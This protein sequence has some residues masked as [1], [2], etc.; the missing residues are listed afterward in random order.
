MSF[1][2][3]R[4]PGAA[5]LS[6]LVLA[7]CAAIAPTTPEEAVGRRA[8]ARIDALV[9]KDYKAAH[10]F[11]TPGYRDKLGY[12]DWI[13]SRPPRAQF[14]SG[15]VVKVACVSADACDIEMETTYD[16]PRGVKGAPKGVIQRVTPERWVR[17][18]GQW[19]LFQAR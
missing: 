3:P 7:G 11:F 6:L 4:L 17:V 8:Q 9:A 1:R 12:E 19:W 18:D 13:R 2:F 5:L 10:A 15:R 16:S 14:L